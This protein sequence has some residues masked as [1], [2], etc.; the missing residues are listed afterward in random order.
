MLQNQP[1]Q[2]HIIYQ[3]VV[4]IVNC[5]RSCVSYYKMSIQFRLFNGRFVQ[6]IGKCFCSYKPDYML[7]KLKLFVISHST[8]MVTI[9]LLD[10]D[11]KSVDRQVK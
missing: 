6:S 9:L 5:F 11:D 2:T 7:D 4:R 10:I 1:W 8:R 3:N